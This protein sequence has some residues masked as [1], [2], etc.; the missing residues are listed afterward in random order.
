MGDGAEQDV[1]ETSEISKN[2][3]SGK[4]E[5]RNEGLGARS[6]TFAQVPGWNITAAS[7]PRD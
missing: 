6:T 7:I 5:S 4:E 2:D 3:K 1:D